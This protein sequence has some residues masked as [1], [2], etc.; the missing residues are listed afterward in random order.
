MKEKLSVVAIVAIFLAIMSAGSWAYFTA[1]E[2][3][4]NVITT[5]GVDITLHEWANEDRT[6][7]FEDLTGVMPGR[8][9]TKIPEVENS[10]ENPVFVRVKLTK[11]IT[12]AE[13]VELTDEVNPD[14]ITIDLN[15]TDW[16]EKDGYYYYKKVLPAGETTEP[17]FTTVSFDAAMGNVF[18]N[19]QVSIDITAQAVQ[20]ANNGENGTDPLKALGWPAEGGAA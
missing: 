13:G 10:G 2:Q 15:E 16:V 12:W 8:Q 17:L 19:A 14:L 6:E 9:V 7:P 5:G 18:Q 1:S 4:H 11:A 3:V 20:S